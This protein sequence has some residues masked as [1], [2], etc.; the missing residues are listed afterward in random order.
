MSLYRDDIAAAGKAINWKKLEGKTLLVTGASGLIGGAVVDLVSGNCPSCR[1][2]A[3]GRNLQ[4]LKARFPKAEY[5]TKDLSE[6]QPEHF[7]HFDYA[8]HAAGGANPALYSSKP[9]EVITTAVHSLEALLRA[10]CHFEPLSCHFEPLSCHFEPLSC[11]FEPAEKSHSLPRI[12]FVS[13]DEVYGQCTQPLITEKDS[14]YVDCTT[15]H[16]CYPSAKRLCE[17]LCASF[18][19]EYGADVVTVRPSHIYGPY[20]TD[21]DN[22]VYA[23]FI[24][25][26][27]KG[28][29]IVMK[30]PGT[31]MRSWCY[32]VDCAAAIVTA[33]L[34]GETGEA[35]NIADNGAEFSIRQLAD[36]ISEV[37]GCKVRMDCPALEESRGYNPVTRSVLSTEKIGALGWRPM[38]ASAKEKIETTISTQKTL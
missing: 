8:V 3:G 12:L 29:D 32:S 25:N 36:I 5:W 18:I 17:S 21:Q 13:S 11:H 20:F 6:V 35:Y 19:S 4:R 23:Q 38:A 16:S 24:R 7:P 2:I 9:V 15:P 27:I 14:G 31:Q 10:S 34:E 33:L 28:E 37:S 22:R 30:S 1:I 26:A